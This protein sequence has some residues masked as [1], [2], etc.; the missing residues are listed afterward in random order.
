MDSAEKEKPSGWHR[1]ALGTHH[2]ERDGH[3][4]DIATLPT[5]SHPTWRTKSGRR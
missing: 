3:C 5:T 2:I 4:K 1:G